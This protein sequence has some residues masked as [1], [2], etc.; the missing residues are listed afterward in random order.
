MVE[1]LKK[2]YLVMRAPF[3]AQLAV[4]TPRCLLAASLP[5]SLGLTLVE[6]KYRAAV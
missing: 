5:P 1:P 4:A 3:R 6:V 2:F